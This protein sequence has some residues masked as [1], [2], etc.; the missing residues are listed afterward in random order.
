[1]ADPGR[2]VPSADELAGVVSTFRDA[3]APIDRLIGRWPARD[4]LWHDRLSFVDID[5]ADFVQI[6]VPCW[7]PIRECL[8]WR[9]IVPGRI[10]NI[11]CETWAC[12]APPGIAVLR[13]DRLIDSD[14][15]SGHE[16]LR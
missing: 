9:V 13:F 3:G 14:D 8:V 6:R 7:K 12:A 5:L 10:G 1:M 16:R 11:S 15:G 2:R 4:L